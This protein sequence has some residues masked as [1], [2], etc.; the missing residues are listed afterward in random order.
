MKDEINSNYSII[1]DGKKTIVF[2]HYFGGDAGSWRWLAKRLQKKHRCILLNLPGFG[3]T[4]PLEEPS[5]FGFATYINACIEELNLEDYILCGHSMGAKLAL[6]AAKLMKGE[7]PDRI[8]LI[9]PSPPTVE[10]MDYEERNRML[11]HPNRAEA[12]ATVQGATIKKLRKKRFEYAVGSQLRIDEASWGWW[13][14]EGMQNNIANRIDDLE[15]PS[16]IIFSKNDPV[17]SPEEMYSEVLPHLKKPSVIA[18]GNV[19][20]LIPME[21]PRKLARQIKR[22]T[23]MKVVEKAD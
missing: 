1:G 9:A 2:I 22:I 6:Y 18:L 21:A 20:H 16:H 17:L 13:L 19:G 11:N 8:I 3:N 23:R 7:K 5:I 4:P 10:N 12:I 14:K 15:I